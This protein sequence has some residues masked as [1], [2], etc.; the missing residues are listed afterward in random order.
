MGEIGLE[1]RPQYCEKIPFAHQLSV[2]RRF[3]ELGVSLNKLIQIHVV[4][5]GVPG[6]YPTL[7]E[8]F[9]RILEIN[10]NYSQ[11][12]ILHSYSGSFEQFKQLKKA[13]PNIIIGIS[14][15]NKDSKQVKRIVVLEQR[16]LFE[17]DY[18]GGCEYQF[19]FPS[20][21]APAAAQG[22]AFL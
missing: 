18:D 16:C 13:Y 15:L 8:L 4:S 6:A 7:L 9:S 1:L 3:F 14:Y 21:Y 19:N 12:I 20:E 5:R 11:M 10:P 22:E 2:F 17:S